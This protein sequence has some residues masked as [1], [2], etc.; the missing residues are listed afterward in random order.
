M[1]VENKNSLTNFSIDKNFS[2][3]QYAPILVGSAFSFL[4]SQR[5]KFKI[6]NAVIEPPPFFSSKLHARSRSRECK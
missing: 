1:M 5:K 3:P 2:V 6:G 4:E